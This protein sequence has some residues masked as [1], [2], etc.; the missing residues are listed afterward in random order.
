MTMLRPIMFADLDDT[1]FQSLRKVPDDQHEGKV[2]VSEAISGNHSYQTIKQQNLF[3]WLSATTD[4][5]PVTARS[6]RSFAN[7]K[8]DFGS[9]FKIVGN[10]AVVIKPDGEVDQ[11]WHEILVSETVKE[12]DTIHALESACMALAAEL[13]IAVRCPQSVENGIRHSVI[14]KQDDPDIKIRLD[15]ILAGVVVPSGWTSHLN[16]NNLAFTVP[17]VSKK[18]ATEYVMSQIPDINQR[19]TF[20]IGDSFTDMPFM[21]LCDFF[22]TPMRGQVA[23]KLISTPS[24]H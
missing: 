18:R 1:F 19:I 11:Q 2:L 12:L 17:S 10:G 22:A 24:N 21:G 7:V 3:T 23:E 9:N 16:S 14:V 4:I 15:E 6:S 8:L 13:G 5:V 20:G